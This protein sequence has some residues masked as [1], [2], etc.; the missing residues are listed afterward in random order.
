ME[1]LHFLTDFVFIADP[2]LVFLIFLSL[3]QS[4]VEICKAGSE[5]GM[6]SDWVEKV[7]GLGSSEACSSNIER[8]FL[9]FARRDLN[10]SIELYPVRCICR[11][12][13]K[14]TCYLDIG[15]LLPHE[16]AH[17]VLGGDD[18]RLS[19]EDTHNHIDNSRM[20]LATEQELRNH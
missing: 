15:V 13:T 11:H 17:Q 4:M 1:S 12:P 7:K 18:S 16:V 19:C 2:F 9:R 8:D 5:L 14:T 6:T 10:I 3:V 20:I